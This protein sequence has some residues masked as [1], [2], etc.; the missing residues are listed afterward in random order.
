M[1]LDADTGALAR[2]LAQVS[3][4]PA[5]LVEAF[6]ERTEQVSLAPHGESPPLRVWREEGFSVRLVSRDETWMVSRD[7]IDGSSFLEAL[8]KTAR[9]MAQGLRPPPRLRS[10]PP[11]ELPDADL[12]RAFT[13]QVERR[14][15]E[16]HL[17]FP[18]R[19]EVQRH[20]RW[21]QIVGREFVGEPERE[22]FWS[23]RA[24]LEG[25]SWGVLLPELAHP[26]AV[27]VASSLAALFRS[28]GASP[29]S[30]RRSD[31]L[32]GSSAAAV[33]LHEA[34]AHALE[35]DTLALTGEPS[36]AIGHR[37]GSDVLD[38]L[39][40]PTSGPPGLRRRTDDEGVPVLRRWLLRRGVVEQPLADRTWALRSQALDPGAG[41][42]Q[43]RHWPPVPRSLHL[44]LLPGGDALVDLAATVADGVYA[45]EASHGFLD[46]ITGSFELRFP[47]GRRLRRG[48]LE[49]RLGA[50]HLRGAVGDLLARI[51]SA[52][53]EVALAG[54]GWCAKGGQRLPVWSTTPGLLLHGV[55]V[56]G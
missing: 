12:A 25:A 28:R 23:L 10:V 36:A 11:P 47:Y 40:D 43:S 17:A 1:F 2:C 20:R 45:A 42:R 33:L 7:S 9:R 18:L 14:L 37:V 38:L 50:F 4:D 44:E 53:C 30:P 46:P 55:E 56:G 48:K 3:E 35:V 41:R 29:P 6:F 27:G 54:A 16:L 31:L 8:R 39:D 21:I 13:A 26:G 32:L 49:E 52:G 22:D 34:V 15:R 51:D 24:S 19:L 5:V